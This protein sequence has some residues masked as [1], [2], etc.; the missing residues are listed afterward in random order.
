VP[1]RP[2]TS[3][4]EDG[5]ACVTVSPL[6]VDQRAHAAPLIA[7]NDDVSRLQRTGL[8]EHGGNRATAAIELRFDDRAFG[9]PVWIGLE[10]ENFSLQQDGFEKLV[11]VELLGRR[12]LD[13]ENL[14]AHGFDEDFVLQ[15]FPCGPSAHR[16][17]ACRSC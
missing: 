9:G 12:D 5:P 3:T 16:P 7:G 11:E 14:A 6:V 15:Q 2:R 8:D 4:G 13:I 17:S 10:I 1:C